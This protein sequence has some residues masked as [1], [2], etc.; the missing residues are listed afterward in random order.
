MFKHK[1]KDVPVIRFI[2]RATG[3]I[4]WKYEV[5]DSL[6]DIKV[7]KSEN[8]FDTLAQRDANYLNQ[9]ESEG[10]PIFPWETKNV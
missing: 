2:V 8:L 5:Y 4:T 1:V 9:L 6:R 3:D 10:S 7:P